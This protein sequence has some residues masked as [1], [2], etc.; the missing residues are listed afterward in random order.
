MSDKDH[1]YYMG[2]A[3]E[4]AS[5]G[6]GLTSP[7]PSVGCII[8][9]ENGDILAEGRTH[10]NRGKH[11][12]IDALDKLKDD[13][14]IDKDWSNFDATLRDY[15]SKMTLYVTL[16][17]CCHYGANPPCVD[18]I[19][20]SNIKRVVVC[21]VDKNQ[22]VN[23][24]GI[25]SLIANGVKVI[26]GICQDSGYNIIKGFNKRILHN[27][28]F[29]TLKLATSIDGKVAMQ[30]G[31]SK[32]ITSE[33]QRLDAHKLRRFNDAI[34]TGI[35]TVIAD[36]PHLTCR[37]PDYS[38]DKQPARI[39]LDTDLQ[40]DLKANICKTADEIRT[41]IFTKMSD[42]SDKTEKNAQLKAKGIEIYEI[43][44]GSM[45][46]SLIDAWYKIA[47]LGFND[48]LVECG[49]RLT[50]SLL[51]EDALIDEIVWY[52]APFIIG[53]EGM[54][55]ILDMHFKNLFE[56]KLY[57]SKIKINVKT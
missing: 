20:K 39:V 42:N 54:P 56:A 57:A 38:G 3:L 46:L 14:N 34:L 1:T 33:E 9:S 19:I 22:I 32:W 23:G 37:H 48:L 25:A 26:E 21:N 40:I 15:F 29:T 11:A 44:G 47:E 5:Q 41:I 12:E 2:M 7:N 50:T 13:L 4:L 6:V 51:Q 18:E 16:E 8:V 52:I 53:A 36:D 30:N 45:S 28:P 10:V 55:G 31:E 17:P 43:K 24:K 35:G 27:L 49:P